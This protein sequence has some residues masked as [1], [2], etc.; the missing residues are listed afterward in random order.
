MTK[1]YTL[2][3]RISFNLLK[4]Q[5]HKDGHVVNI[6]GR[7]ARIMKLLCD[8]INCVVS[9]GYIQDEVWSNVHVGETSL[10]KAISNLRK[11]LYQ[12]ND[13]ACEIKTISGEGYMLIQDESL[14]ISKE[15]SFTLDNEMIT[16]FNNEHSDGQITKPF[17]EETL[18]SIQEEFFI[19][20]NYLLLVLFIPSIIATILSTGIITLLSIVN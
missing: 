4:R 18:E 13:L 8:N 10:T 12:F 17:R 11:S 20:K 6:G 1:E 7:E 9:K 16:Q 2:G 3:N 14:L 5:L 19:N 15:K